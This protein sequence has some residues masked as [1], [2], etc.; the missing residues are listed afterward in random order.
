MT[1]ILAVILALS[2]SLCAY[3]TFKLER[4]ATLLLS[5][6]S[7]LDTRTAALERTTNTLALKTEV[8]KIREDVSVLLAQSTIIIRDNA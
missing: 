6:Q 1:R 5:T 7:S 3:Q 8:G 4:Q 2:L